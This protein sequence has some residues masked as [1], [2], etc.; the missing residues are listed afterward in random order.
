ML[1]LSYILVAKDPSRPLA[2]TDVPKSLLDATVLCFV[3][4]K[5]VIVSNLIKVRVNGP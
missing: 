4:F 2:K 5:K 3:A 1:L